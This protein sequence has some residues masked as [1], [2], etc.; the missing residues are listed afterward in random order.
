MTNSICRNHQKYKQYLSAYRLAYARAKSVRKLEIML[1]FAPVIA[2]LA[3]YQLGPYIAGGSKDFPVNLLNLCALAGVIMLLVCDLKLEPLRAMHRRAANI[4]LEAYDTAV[5]EFPWHAAISGERPSQSSLDAEARGYD[6][7]PAKAHPPELS[8]EDSWYPPLIE[9]IAIEPA[10]LYCLRQ[11]CSFEIMYRRKYMQLFLLPMLIITTSLLVVQIY[12]FGG[13]L[14]NTCCTLIT[15]S[16][17]FRMLLLGLTVQSRNCQVLQE[18]KGAIEEAL[19]KE[20][21]SVETARAFQD[22]LFLTRDTQP[23]I[24]IAGFKHIKL[25]YL[26]VLKAET[27]ALIKAAG[28]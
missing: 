14:P 5:L 13:S 23:L 21:T 3:L 7:G 26:P 1:S 11:N 6:A 28:H 25:K 18:L 2:C 10:R 20:E 16:P 22:R 12:L 15:A 4:D 19:K 9:T 27:E 17:I 8:L 24:S